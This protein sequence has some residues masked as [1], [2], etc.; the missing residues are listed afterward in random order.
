MV[1]RFQWSF[2]KA[3]DVQEIDTTGYHL[4]MCTS[5]GRHAEAEGTIGGSDGESIVE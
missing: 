1:L 5:S 3:C 2:D 4:Y